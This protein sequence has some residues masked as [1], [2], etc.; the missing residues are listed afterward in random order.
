[1]RDVLF[2]FV[3]DLSHLCEG[4]ESLVTAAVSIFFNVDCFFLGFE[5]VH[6]LLD[7]TDGTL[8]RLVFIHI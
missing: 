8:F 1:M 5:N 3:N 4:F 6:E 7:L 2:I